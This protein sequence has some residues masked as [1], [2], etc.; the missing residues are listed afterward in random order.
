MAYFLKI[1]G[2]EGEST[3]D[4]HKGDIDVLSMSWGLSQSLTI[5]SSSSSTPR[6]SFQDLNF[7]MRTNTASGKLMKACAEGTHLKEAIFFAQ[8]NQ[9]DDPFL[10]ITLT[11][12]LVSSI[13]ESGDEEPVQEVALGYAKIKYQYASAKSDG[14]LTP[15]EDFA[16][17]VK[18]NKKA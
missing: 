11:D 17:N 3:D 9:Q 14:S 12:V 15:A 18:E 13:S 5:Q 7:T 16:W 4:Q 1:V 2:Y 6:A 10:L 8:R